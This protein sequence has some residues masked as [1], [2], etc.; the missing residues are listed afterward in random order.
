MRIAIVGLGGVGGYLCAYLSQGSSEVVGFARGK[1]LKAIQTSGIKV[2]DNKKEFIQKIDAREL[3]KADGYFDIVL[4]CVKSYDL[5]DSYKQIKNYCDKDTTLISFSNGV[6]NGDKL[7]E[8]SN[9]IVLDGCIYILSPMLVL[10]QI[11]LR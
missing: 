2:I 1:H 6:D 11:G 8:L 3:N 4:F 7:R 5:L 10:V 9:S